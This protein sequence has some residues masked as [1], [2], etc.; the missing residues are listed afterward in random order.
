[1]RLPGFILR[2]RLR[3]EP[4]SHSALARA[5]AHTRAGTGASLRAYCRVAT[6]T[7]IC[8][9]MRRFNGSLSANAWKAGNGTS[10]PS[11]R[12]RGRRMT[13]FRPPEDDFAW[14]RAGARRLTLRLMRV[15]WTAQRRPI[16]L[17]PGIGRGGRGEFAIRLAD[18]AIQLGRSIRHETSLRIRASRRSVFNRLAPTPRE[19]TNVAGATRMS[20]PTASVASPPASLHVSTTTRLRGR[21]ARYLPS[22]AVGQRRSSTIWPVLLHT[23]IWDSFPPRSIARCSTAGL[24]SSVPR[25]RSRERL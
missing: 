10:A 3:D 4:P 5:A 7:S 11:R 21:V 23:H 1:M 18:F 6:L 22:D 16:F 2:P 24:L 15:P 13:I 14:H 8:S 19:R 9:T 17:E 25:A 12:T 20:C